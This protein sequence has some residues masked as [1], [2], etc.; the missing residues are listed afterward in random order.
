MEKTFFCTMYQVISE[1]KVI[2]I[3]AETIGEALFLFK[4]KQRSDNNN[5]KEDLKLFP[6]I[7]R[8]VIVVRE[9]SKDETHIVKG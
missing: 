6:C 3:E 9:S 1:T 8:G 4:M 2:E 5:D 7:V